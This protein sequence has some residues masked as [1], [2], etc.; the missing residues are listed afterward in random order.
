MATRHDEGGDPRDGDYELL[1]PE[2]FLPASRIPEAD[3]RMGIDGWT[4]E[5]GLI[6]FAASLDRRNPL[7]VV[8]AWAML[9]VLVLPTIILVGL[10]LRT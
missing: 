7:H 4:G 5:A 9:V 10:L 8:A 6:A 2:H 1:T 3:R